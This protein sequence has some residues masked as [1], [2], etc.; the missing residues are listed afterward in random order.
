MLDWNEIDCVF[1][2]MD[3]TL[4]DLNFDNHFWLEHVPL[5]YSQ[6][7]SLPL[8]AAKEILY[9]KMMAIRGQLKW[10]SIDYWSQELDL[11][12]LQLKQETAHLIGLRPRVQTFLSALG[13]HGKTVVLFTNAQE[14]TFNLKMQKVGLAHYFDAVITS[15]QLGFAKEQVGVWDKLNSIFPFDASRSLF[16]DDSFT[17][18]DEAKRHGPGSFVWYRSTRSQQKRDST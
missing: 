15:H 2:D 16:V 4:L 11:P 8:S 14:T 12:I 18:L 1:L 7:Q 6:K 17:V 13:N 5:R 9:A 3:G 10:Y